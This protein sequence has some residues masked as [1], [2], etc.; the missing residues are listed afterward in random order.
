MC[1]R[2]QCNKINAIALNDKLQRMTTTLTLNTRIS[3]PSKHL[4][5]PG[6]NPGQ[7]REI[8]QA[9]VHCPDHGRLRP[10]RFVIVRGGQRHKLGELLIQRVLAELPEASEI[11]L[12]KERTRFSFAPC[13]VTVV[14]NPMKNHKVPEIEQVLSGGALCM[15]ML[16]AAHQMGF[17][18]Q[19]LTG[20]AAYDPAIH[21]ALGLGANEQILGFIHIG[22]KTGEPPERERP[23]VDALSVE[24]AL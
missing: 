23:D 2:S 7:L 3:S 17:G 9:A 19:W 1:D 12:E 20:F 4:A 22:S 13:I 11:R 14:L 24:A 15:N 6:P 21:Q 16:H 18:A 10:W 8:L 5:E